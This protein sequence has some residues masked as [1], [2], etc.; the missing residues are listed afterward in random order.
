MNKLD[1]KSLG[2]MV[3]DGDVVVLSGSA[4]QCGEMVWDKVTEGV[5]NGL[6]NSMKRDARCECWW[7]FMCKARHS[8]IESVGGE[9]SSLML[10]ALQM[11]MP[12]AVSKVDEEHAKGGHDA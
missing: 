4:D 6:M 1:G 8:L 11:T 7:A 12:M 5:M 9:E 3:A 10:T 2:Q